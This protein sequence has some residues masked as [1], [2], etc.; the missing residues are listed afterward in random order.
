MKWKKTIDAR[1]YSHQALEEMRISAVRRVEAGESPEAV[2]VGLGMNRRTIYRWLA[3]CCP[4]SARPLPSLATAAKSRFIPANPFFDN[5]L[6]IESPPSHPSN[7]DFSPFLDV[8]PSVIADSACPVILSILSNPT[9][10]VTF[11]R[12]AVGASPKLTR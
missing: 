4:L 8:N 6:T 9:I 10:A 1:S 2:V 11:D 7:G 12:V 3:V 5:P